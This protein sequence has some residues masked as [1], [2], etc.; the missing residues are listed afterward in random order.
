MKFQV[1][2]KVYYQMHLIFQHRN[3]EKRVGR[4]AD[5][6]LYIVTPDSRN[7]TLGLVLEIRSLVDKKVQVV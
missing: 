7:H 3:S 6:N 1:I 2:N 5:L 4:S